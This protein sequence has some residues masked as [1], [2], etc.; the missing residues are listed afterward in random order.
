M[1]NPKVEEGVLGLRDNLPARLLFANLADNLAEVCAIL[2]LLG[3]R[4]LPPEL[5]SRLRAIEGDLRE[6]SHLCRFP[7]VPTAS[8]APTLRPS[9][10][11]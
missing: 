7:P 4:E 6:M 1:P 8:S 3:H 5:L 11:A 9:R 2:S 10:T